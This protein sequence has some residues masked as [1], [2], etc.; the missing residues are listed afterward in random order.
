M[1]FNQGVLRLLASWYTYLSS[2]KCIYSPTT[3]ILTFMCYFH[4]FFMCGKNHWEGVK[5]W[6]RLLNFS[7]THCSFSMGNYWDFTLYISICALDIGMGTVTHWRNKQN[8]T[9]TILTFIK[10]T[11]LIV[12]R[13][14]E[15]MN[16]W[17]TFFSHN[18]LTQKEYIFLLW[19]LNR[20]K[21]TGR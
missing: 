15:W 17:M 3:I 9:D 12:K 14:A 20:N 18:L 4:I 10:L 16:D 13:S 6:Y 11:R 8:H 5:N 1:W 2:R 7:V 21:T 19:S